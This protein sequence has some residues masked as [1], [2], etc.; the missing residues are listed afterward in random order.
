MPFIGVKYQWSRFPE[1]KIILSRSLST[2]IGARSHTHVLGRV[3]VRPIEDNCCGASD[4][5]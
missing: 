4:E 3:M 5:A 2:D 1:R